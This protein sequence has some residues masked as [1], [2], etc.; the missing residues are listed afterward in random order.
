[1]L[2]LMKNRTSFIIAHRL[3]T[4][5]SADI[6]MVIDQGKIVERGSH[7]ELVISGGVYSKMYYSQLHRTET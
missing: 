1:M 4:I 2:K 5:R 7:E 6:I 3:S